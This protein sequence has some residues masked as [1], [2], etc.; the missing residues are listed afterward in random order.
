MY[1]HELDRRIDAIAR[2]QGGAFNLDQLR[3]AGG[4]DDAALHR[5]SIGRWVRLAP[6]VLAVASYPGTFERQ[7]WAAVLGEPAAA[8]GGLTA[9]HVRGFHGFNPGRPEIVVPPNGNARSPIATVHRYESPAVSTVRGLS[10]TTPAQTLFDVAP[11]ISVQRLERVVDDEL[12]RGRLTVEALDERLSFY[13]QT[14]RAGLPI[15]RSIV[16]D[17]RAEG[18]TPSVSELERRGDRILRRLRG[19]P[20]IVA[21]AGFSWL[22]G[23]TARVDRYL[24]DCGIIVEFD[25]RRWHARVRDFDK[26]RWRDN[27]AAAAGLVVLRFTWT[28]IISRP[29][30]VLAIIEDT[31]RARA[32]RAA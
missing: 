10:V 21:E 11:R 17:R 9:A 20:A 23:G 13:A 32:T 4:D 1:D 29:R 31:R 18:P 26:D 15:M 19:R 2:R 14:R 22:D 3:T 30:E 28:H 6:A 5:I 12:L 24:P 25:G 7:C 27:E 8:L 16:A